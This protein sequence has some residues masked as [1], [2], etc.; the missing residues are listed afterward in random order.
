[1]DNENCLKELKRK[2]FS[3]DEKSWMDLMKFFPEKSH[4][5]HQKMLIKYLCD[6]ELRE[7][8]RKTNMTIS[9]K[10]RIK[11]IEKFLEKNKK[12][13][14]TKSRPVFHHY[15]EHNGKI[16]YTNCHLLG[17]I[18]KNEIDG[19]NP[20]YNI[21]NYNLG[22]FPDYEKVIPE[23]AENHQFAYVN[24]SDVLATSKKAKAEKKE[25]DTHIVIFDDGTVGAYSAEYLL[26]C[27]AVLGQDKIKLARNSKIDEWECRGEKM[28]QNIQ[29]IVV[30]AEKTNSFLVVSAMRVQQEII[31]S[32][33][34]K[35]A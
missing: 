27:F 6:N 26:H 14:N 34:N 21:D 2:G 3:I 5:I 15:K 7:N 28:R 4:D 18:D 10:K 16:I 12:N 31:D 17:V 9:T 22:V 23:L 32:Y 20:A 1:M 35:I 33:E 30:T 25:F 13:Y 24:Y 19:I 29:T 8:C 11:A